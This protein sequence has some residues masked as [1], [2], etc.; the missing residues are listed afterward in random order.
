[1]LARN[2]DAAEVIEVPNVC[3]ELVWTFGEGPG[4]E[5]HFF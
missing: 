4:K 3:E 2:V 1:M 5:S